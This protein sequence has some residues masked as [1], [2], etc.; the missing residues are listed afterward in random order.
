MASTGPSPT[1]SDYERDMLRV[2]ESSDLVHN[3]SLSQSPNTRN[4][5]EHESLVAPHRTVVPSASLPAHGQWNTTMPSATTNVPL[6]SPSPSQNGDDVKSQ[7]TRPS[8]SKIDSLKQWGIS[9]YKCT[10]QI[11]SEKL[12]KGCKTVDSELQSQIEQLRDTQKKYANIL[13]LAQSLTTHFYHVVQTQHALA[14]CF[15]DLAHKSP[16]LQEEFLYNS[17]TQRNL[18]KNGDTLLGA[19]NFFVSCLSTLCNKTVGDTLLTVK[20]YENA[21]LEFDAYRNDMEDMIREDAASS[22]LEEA[23][24]NFS[25]HKEK[26]EK[27]RS[28]VIVKMKFLEENKV[29]V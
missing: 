10:R 6:T 17:E 16:E 27:L 8:H 2:T 22:K 14:E 19:L 29:C 11:L 9:T 4:P 15:S 28:D 12:G 26:Y 3:G 23:K 20:L 7:V 24:R 13:Q 1:D 25:S 21:R 18:G 5:E